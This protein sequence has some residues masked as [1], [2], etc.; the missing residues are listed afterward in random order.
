MTMPQRRYRIARLCGAGAILIGLTGLLGWLTGN[1]VLTS[2]VPGYKP[3]AITVSVLVLMLG[4]L[5]VL[6][7]RPPMPRPLAGLGLAI[8]AAVAVF[9]LLEI[10]LLLTGINPTIED[11]LLRLFPALHQN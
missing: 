6:A 8:T 1:A 9:T 2:I 7:A 3:I 4:G 5:L 10:L 11:A